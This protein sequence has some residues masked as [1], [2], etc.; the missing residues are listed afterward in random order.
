MKDKIDFRLEKKT[1]QL[2]E[3][4]AHLNDMTTSGYMNYLVEKSIEKIIDDISYGLTSEELLS[5]ILDDTERNELS[6]IVKQNIALNFAK[7]N[8]ENED[9]YFKIQSDYKKVFT[10]Y[11]KNKEN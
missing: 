11:I 6:A 8:F 10:D 9:L 3:I 4:A 5:R 2:V 7:E 1:K